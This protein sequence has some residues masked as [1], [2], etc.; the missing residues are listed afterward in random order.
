MKLKAKIKKNTLSLFVDD[1][2]VKDIVV[3]ATEKEPQITYF[4]YDKERFD[5]ILE[6]SRAGSHTIFKV[7][8]YPLRV[9][10][11]SVI[12]LESKV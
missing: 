8:V 5:I 7:Y 4:K 11:E 2:H 1:E 9:F 10:D 3:K 12:K 6:K